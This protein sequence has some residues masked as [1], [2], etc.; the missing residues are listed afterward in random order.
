MDK[1]EPH[2]LAQAA[3]PAVVNV[4]VPMELLWDFDGLMDVKKRVLGELG[5]QACTSGYDIRWRGTRDFVVNPARE[6]RAL[7]DITISR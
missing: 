2:H 6:I 7:N 1:L 3:N 5:C 4:D